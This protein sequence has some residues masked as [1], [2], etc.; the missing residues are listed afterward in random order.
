MRSVQV[1]TVQDATR[2]SF[3]KLVKLKLTSSQARPAQMSCEPLQLTYF[4]RPIEYSQLRP[5]S[6][7]V[8]LIDSLLHDFGELL[9]ASLFLHIQLL[10]M[11][12]RKRVG[13]STALVKI[14]HKL[15]PFKIELF[16]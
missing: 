5:T 9:A 16:N 8:K 15:T 6:R 11:N 14:K 13:L 10:N 7:D 3:S 12:Q 1:F 2:I 4:S